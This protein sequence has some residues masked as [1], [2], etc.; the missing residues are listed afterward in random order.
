MFRPVVIP[1]DAP[2][3]T[4]TIYATDSDIVNSLLEGLSLEVP[5]HFLI[6]RKHRKTLHPELIEEEGKKICYRHKICKSFFSNFQCC[7]TNSQGT[8]VNLLWHT[9]V[10][11]HTSWKIATPEEGRCLWGR[12]AFKCNPVY[13]VLLIF[14]SSV[15]TSPW[16]CFHREKIKYPNKLGI[17]TGKKDT[18][19][20]EK[21][22]ENS[23]F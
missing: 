12:W 7:A 15:L 6:L 10:L 3:D 1:Q 4:R 13:H 16:A 19:R 9:N 20:E 23:I 22:R 11:W 8:P 14:T 18:C 2:D 5:I 21:Y 17:E